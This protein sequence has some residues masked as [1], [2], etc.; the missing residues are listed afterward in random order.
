MGGARK[1]LRDARPPLRIAICD[2]NAPGASHCG[3]IQAQHGDAPVKEAGS[4]RGELVK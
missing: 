1:R 4:L 2:E 3:P